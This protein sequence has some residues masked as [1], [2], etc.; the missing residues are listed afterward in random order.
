ME[1]KL[2]EEH[3]YRRAF[4]CEGCSGSCVLLINGP[5]YKVHS[6]ICE[7][8]TEHDWVEIPINNNIIKQEKPEVVDE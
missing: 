2:N 3:E 6:P 4:K 1:F 8:A 7:Y 5:T